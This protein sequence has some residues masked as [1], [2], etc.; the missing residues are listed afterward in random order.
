MIFK[1]KKTPQGVSLWRF[2]FH[3]IALAIYEFTFYK[4]RQ[5]IFEFL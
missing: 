3:F 5:L 4:N 1:N 2:V